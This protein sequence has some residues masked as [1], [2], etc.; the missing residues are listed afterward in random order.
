MI[1]DDE[2]EFEYREYCDRNTTEGKVYFYRVRA[3][4]GKT[5]G[6]YSDSRDIMRLKPAKVYSVVLGNNKV[7][8]K[9][10]KSAKA[11]GY[12]LEIWELTPAGE[13]AGIV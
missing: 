4:A 5:Y 8:I 2:E 7:T 6:A 9:W 3:T 10:R 1:D 11:E 12:Y 13:W